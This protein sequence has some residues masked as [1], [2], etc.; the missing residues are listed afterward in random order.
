MSCLGGS[1]EAPRAWVRLGPDGVAE[2]VGRVEGCRVEGERTRRKLCHGCPAF[3]GLDRDGIVQSGVAAN[4]EPYALSEAEYEAWQDEPERFWTRKDGGSIWG[5]RRS[6]TLEWQEHWNAYMQGY[7]QARPRKDRDPERERERSRR[8][9][10]RKRHGKLP[11]HAETGEVPPARAGHVRVRARG[12][13]FTVT[14][15]GR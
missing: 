12:G 4:G 8:Y 9:R 15:G 10:A 13:R 11:A 7:R 3:R 6:G 1:W 2:L 14:Q 5:W